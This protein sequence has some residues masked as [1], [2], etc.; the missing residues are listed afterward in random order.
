MME[1]SESIS[2]HRAPGIAY[3]K[4]QGLVG[5]YSF[6]LVLPKSYAINLGIGKGDFVKVFL[7]NN[8]IVIEKA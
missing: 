8:K 1:N 5:D 4:I 3:R 7:E 2:G 6:S